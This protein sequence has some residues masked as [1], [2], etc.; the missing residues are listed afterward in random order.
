MFLSI[1][2]CSVVVLES[3]WFEFTACSPPSYLGYVEVSKRELQEINIHNSIKSL[4]MVLISR[5]LS[6]GYMRSF[7]FGSKFK[8]VQACF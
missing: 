6:M 1:D 2:L 8:T 4:S 7:V 3:M 5:G